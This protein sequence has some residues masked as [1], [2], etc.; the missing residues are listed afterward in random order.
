MYIHNLDPI[1]FKILNFSI[2]WYSLSYLFGFIFSFFYAKFLIQ[3]GYVK[4]N[5]SYF[6]DFL[7]WAVVSVIIGGRLGYIF[8]YNLNFYS[9]NPL[10]ILKIWEG[11][12]SF[13]GGLLGLIFSIFLY[14][15]LKKIDFIEL[16]N[17]VSACAPFGLF[18]GRIANFVNKELVG[19]PTDSNWGVLF[20][21]NDVL[22]HPS[23]LYESLFEGLVLFFLILYFFFKNYHKFVN[24]FAVFLI[25]YGLSRFAL[26][27]YREPDQHI[28]YI[29]QNFSMGQL[30]S[31]PMI[32]IGIVLLR[33]KK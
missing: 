25:F 33:Y 24:I 12:M 22:R 32:I 8:F 9:E 16:S 10:F 7:S 6:E 15:K 14:S 5:F 29:F 2:Y 11:G 28:G 17:L 3:K 19:K 13:H 1:A 31:F 26:E 18:L 4:L 27:F 20:I 23:Q 21:E 30:L